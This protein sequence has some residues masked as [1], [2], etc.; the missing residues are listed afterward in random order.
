MVGVMVEL[1]GHHPSIVLEGMAFYELLQENITSLRRSK[2]NTTTT[3]DIFNIVS[4]LIEKIISP[5]NIFP[6]VCCKDSFYTC[7]GSI[8]C[9]I[10]AVEYIMKFR[11]DVI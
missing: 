6:A 2:L 1:S 4:P 7:D 8:V 10:A 5:Q 11:N 9:Q 3:N